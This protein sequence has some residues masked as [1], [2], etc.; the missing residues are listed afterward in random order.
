MRAKA[1]T[2]ALKQVL[3]KVLHELGV[4]PCC[5]VAV[6]VTRMLSPSGFNELLG[7]ALCSFQLR[8]SL[9]DVAAHQPRGLRKGDADAVDARAARDMLQAM[10]IAAFEQVFTE[11]QTSKPARSVTPTCTCDTADRS[12]TSTALLHAC[13]LALSTQPRLSS[14]LLADVDVGGPP[15]P[16]LAS[17]STATGPS[18]AH[19]PS[20]WEYR[21][22]VR[23]EVYAAVCTLRAGG[24]A[25]ALVAGFGD[26]ARGNEDGGGV[27]SSRLSSGSSRGVA[28]PITPNAAI[29]RVGEHAATLQCAPTAARLHTFRS[30]FCRKC[31]VYSCAR[32][33][34]ESDVEAD[35]HAS[36]YLNIAL[37]SSLAREMNRVHPAGAMRMFQRHVKGC[38][39]SQSSASSAAKRRRM[40]AAD[41]A[42]EAGDTMGDQDSV[43]DDLDSDADGGDDDSVMAA[44]GAHMSD[45]DGEAAT[46]AP[47][48]AAAAGT[49]GRMGALQSK[50]RTL[51]TLESVRTANAN[52]GKA[53][54]GVR[55]QNVRALS[56]HAHGDLSRFPLHEQELDIPEATLEPHITN[57]VP[58]FLMYTARYRLLAQYS[59]RLLSGFAAE[60]GLHTALLPADKRPHTD[61]VLLQ[62][63][64]L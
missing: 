13:S 30:L 36:V 27:S 29:V 11:I 52:E 42:S 6:R 3:F 37:P 55:S 41:G 15:A 47:A 51:A 62:R 26:A 54:G 49:A 63:L 1:R 60:G 34:N 21:I 16:P 50:V 24:S 39:W 59:Q 10:N 61:A 18:R 19:L 44:G 25:A 2:Y 32:H 40:E 12:L 46:A 56:E 7:A 58:I 57:V 8:D 17:N 14:I 43:R 9:D 33:G 45:S 38:D 20:Q 5:S 22:Q 48:S 4:L 64:Y 35:T 28:A 23:P 53:E 31:A